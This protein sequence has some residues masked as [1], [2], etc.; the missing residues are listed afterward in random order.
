MEG[1]VL[2]VGDNRVSEMG[3]EIPSKLKE[4][5]RIMFGK[6]SGTDVKIDNNEFMIMSETEV[7]MIL[8]ERSRIAR[9]WKRS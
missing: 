3:I 9:T 1:I 2:A 4:G 7:L 5:N 8:P 6:Y